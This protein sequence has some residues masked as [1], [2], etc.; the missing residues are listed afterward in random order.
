M[1]VS[2]A[3]MREGGA[4]F[5]MPEVKKIVLTRVSEA[6]DSCFGIYVA[7]VRKLTVE[8]PPPGG[9]DGWWWWRCL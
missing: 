2:V 5:R 1:P 7:R 4:V 6:G 3:G 8:L 9:V